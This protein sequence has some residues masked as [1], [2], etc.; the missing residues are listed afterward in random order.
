MPARARTPLVRAN[1]HDRR[2]SRVREIGRGVRVS[3]D[4]R[5]VERHSI[6]VRPKLG[7]KHTGLIDDLADLGCV[8]RQ[9]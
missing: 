1:L 9:G 2:S 8:L 6:L 4:S 7:Q 5:S 3:F